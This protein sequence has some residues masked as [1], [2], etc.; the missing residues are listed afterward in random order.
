ML[1][2]TSFWAAGKGP[3]GFGLHASPF[4]LLRLVGACGSK[5]NMFPVDCLTS[6][7][8][9]FFFEVGLIMSYTVYWWQVW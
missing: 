8:F 2:F 7:G 6:T 5:S 1:P 3:S 4:V 9:F